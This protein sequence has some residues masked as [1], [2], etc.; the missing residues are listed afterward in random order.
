MTGDAAGG[1]F[2][3][4]TSVIGCTSKLLLKNKPR[5]VGVV[6]R[7]IEI[8]IGEKNEIV[9]RT[10]EKGIATV[11]KL[12]GKLKEGRFRQAS[13]HTKLGTHK[14]AMNF[15]RRC[16]KARRCRQTPRNLSGS[17]RSHQLI[18]FD[19]VA[20]GEN[21]ELLLDKD[22]D[23]LGTVVF[24]DHAGYEKG[25]VETANIN[26][27]LG[28]NTNTMPLCLLTPLSHVCLCVDLVTCALCRARSVVICVRSWLPAH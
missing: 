28:G 26:A 1:P 15:V 21:G 3:L 19:F 20:K 25:E 5:E 17:S 22:K 9:V 13:S 8:C 18:F 2:T 4:D 16:I 6:R 7:L 27:E 11:A 12:D 10:L 24:S 14:D 23:L